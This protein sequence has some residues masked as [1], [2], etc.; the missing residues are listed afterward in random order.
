M[1]YQE[2]FIGALEGAVE[3]TLLN[4]NVSPAT[5][6]LAKDPRL[7]L[8]RYTGDEERENAFRIYDAFAYGL[9]KLIRES[10]VAENV[11][12]FPVPTW[13]VDDLSWRTQNRL[14]LILSMGLHA[15]LRELCPYANQDELMRDTR[16]KPVLA[17]LAVPLWNLKN[18]L[19]AELPMS[20]FYYAGCNYYILDTKRPISLENIDVIHTFT[21]SGDEKWFMKIHQVIDFTI[22]PAIPELAV[23]AALSG[24]KN[25]WEDPVFVE[26]I[27]RAME[28]SLGPVSAITGIL[29]RMDE[30]CDPHTYFS[31]VRGFYGIPLNL[32]FEGIEEL[33][34]KPLTL[35]GETGG[36]DPSIHFLKKA[37]SFDISQDSYFPK[38][39]LYMPKCF[40]D[41]LQL[42]SQLRDFAVWHAEHGDER[43]K[44]L[45][46]GLIKGLDDFETEH[47]EREVR[48][49]IR[50]FGDSHGTGKPPTLWLEKIREH[51]RSHYIV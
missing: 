9:E 36:Q 20:Y 32:L 38:M 4:K 16:E 19:G 29:A 40:R 49:Y 3:I 31:Q 12:R 7:L 22:A 5:G 6:F 2:N 8:P 17:Q 48:R 37:L 50:D 34:G 13:P 24:F 28:N 25:F 15:Y 44:I 27:T 21:G 42:N 41:V 1:G 35:F 46:N 45:Y 51:T 11:R 10:R 23:A 18:T 47:L 39:Q 26:R 14:K 43:P 33:R 30:Q